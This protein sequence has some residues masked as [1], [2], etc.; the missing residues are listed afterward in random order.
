MPII[1][2]ISVYICR[3]VIC[4]TELPNYRWQSRLR[5]TGLPCGVNTK[6]TLSDQRGFALRLQ[7]K[8]MV[9]LDV[10]VTCLCVCVLCMWLKA[11]AAAQLMIR[12]AGSFMHLQQVTKK[13]IHAGPLQHTHIKQCMWLVLLQK[14]KIMTCMM[15]A[16][17]TVQKEKKEKR[18]SGLCKPLK[19]MKLSVTHPV[20]VCLLIRIR[21]HTVSHFSLLIV[22]THH[23]RA[24]SIS[25]TM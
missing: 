4:H 24:V 5:D 10:T 11:A 8:K 25:L 14:L 1:T 16:A 19:H 20:D 13:L 6:T 23:K 9:R 17:V 7:D 21:N 3:Y 22:Q 2:L 15:W 12:R 18:K